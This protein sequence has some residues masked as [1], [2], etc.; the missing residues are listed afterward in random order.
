MNST[1]FLI[2]VFETHFGKT[3]QCCGHWPC[4]RAELWEGPPQWVLGKWAVSLLFNMEMRC[5]RI[6]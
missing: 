3:R 5:L 4:G 2:R 1:Q 6:V